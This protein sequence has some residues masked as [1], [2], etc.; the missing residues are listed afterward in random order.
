MSTLTVHKTTTRPSIDAIELRDRRPLPSDDIQT[1]TPSLADDVRSYATADEDEYLD[2][3]FGWVIVGC[4]HI[5][6][7]RNSYPDIE[8]N[9][10]SLG[11]FTIAF[12]CLG[13]LY[14]WGVIQAELN[15]R[16]LASPQLLSVIGGLDAFF[17]A[18]ICLPVSE[19]DF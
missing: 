1:A 3:G 15:N 7:V 12:H 10:S 17:T 19:T 6:L 11:T 18:A 16:G 13:L 14:A 9:L 2:G 5:D 8:I 4:E